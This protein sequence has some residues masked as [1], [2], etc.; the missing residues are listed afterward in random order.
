M[1]LGR[2]RNHNK[3]HKSL[4]FGWS[5]VLLLSRRSTHTNTHT[6]THTHTHNGG[7]RRCIQGSRL[8][9]QLHRT[10][11]CITHVNSQEL[12]MTNTITM[13]S[14]VSGYRSLAKEEGDSLSNENTLM[15]I[16][17]QLL[18]N[19]LLFILIFGMSATVD[20]RR[21]KQQL[22]NC[23]A[24][25]AGILMQ[26]VIMPLLG[27]IAVISLKNYGL[28]APMGITLLIV[29][30][31]PGGSYSNWWCSL[32]N[33]DLALSVAMT[34]L[35]T[36]ISIAALPAN[37]VMYS[38]FA[39]GFDAEQEKNV[40]ASVDFVKLIISLAIVIV[41]IL[42]GLFA[43]YKIDS[44]RFQRAA[45]AGGTISGILLIALSAVFST[46]GDSNAKPWNQHWSFYVGV[47]L[48]CVA[49]LALANIIAKFAR[50][51]KPEIVTLSV[52][53]S[54][55]N[56]G[57]ATT[58]VLAM[59]SDSEEVAQAMAVPLFYGL[60]EMG[61]LG[62]YCLVA[63]KL[64]WTKAPYDEK[65]CVVMSKT[66]EVVGENAEDNDDD[67]DDITA[68][69]DSVAP[70]IKKDEE[71]GRKRADSDDSVTISISDVSSKG[72][73]TSKT[74]SSSQEKDMEHS[75]SLPPRLICN[76]IPLKQVFRTINEDPNKAFEVT[77]HR[78]RHVE[79]RDEYS[80]GTG[81]HISRFISF[82]GKDYNRNEN[83]KF[84][85]NLL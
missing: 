13:S 84:E 85:D 17:S 12:S 38:H 83:D 41:A 51:E 22:R 72:T 27:F 44:R 30:S 39:Y 52:E 43:T 23:Y 33:A 48:P 25:T 34:A 16:L 56:T 73:N 46:A 55:Q 69:Q 60:V 79:S 28:T 29:T 45:N 76:N 36:M 77:E 8:E 15:G 71:G 2:R 11:P 50:L 5:F 66:Y 49:G 6:H 54:Y 75:R 4:S 67:D 78:L 81:P 14:I 74:K 42:S 40:L 47:S 37:L 70:T 7:L 58:A 20:I 68:L 82:K 62:M 57:I 26:F 10:I 63:W 9:Q 3:N 61:V 80:S 21:I 65:I 53:C 19:T 1:I 31:S 59:F 32:F 24:I 64:G 35:S 18:S